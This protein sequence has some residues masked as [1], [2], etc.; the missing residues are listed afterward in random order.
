MARTRV[1][2]DPTRP[3]RWVNLVRVDPRR[4]SLAPPGTTGP[5]VARIVGAS[6]APND[7][8]GL[9][10]LAWI[11]TQGTAR[12]SIGTEGPGIIGAPL[13]PMMPV[14]RGVGID[15][16]GFLVYAVADRAAP[17]LIARA[18]DLAGCLPERLALT[19]ETAFALSADRDI[20]GAS[21][22]RDLPPVFALTLRA[23]Q[24]AARVFPEVRPVPPS[25]WYDA[26]HRRVR[27]QRGEDGTVRV[28]TVGGGSRVAP[29]WGSS[30]VTPPA[31]PPTP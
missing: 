7:A 4:V 3:D 19:P 15:E 24:G 28:H 1:R 5:V 17:D 20:A 21:I 23:M 2:P 18:L 22:S 13:L 26:Q 6:M 29:T 14:T 12:W 16:H 30:H 11:E 31:S 9:T 8:R 27:Y 10:R 25:V